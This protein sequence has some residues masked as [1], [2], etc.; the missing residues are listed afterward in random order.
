M[1]S[2]ETGMGEEDQLPSLHKRQGL[3][4]TCPREKIDCEGLPHLVLS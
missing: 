2:N 4:W 3:P 1:D